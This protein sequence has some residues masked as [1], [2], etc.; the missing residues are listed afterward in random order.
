[1]FCNELSEETQVTDKQ[2]TVWG[3]EEQCKGNPGGLL[4]H[5]AP[6]LRFYGNEVSFWAVILLGL[7][8]V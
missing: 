7:Y 1:M 2:K 5:V 4:C 8:L 3:V 6:S